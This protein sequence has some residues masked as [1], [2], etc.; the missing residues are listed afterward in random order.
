[1]QFALQLYSWGYGANSRLGYSSGKINTQP[2][3]FNI[4]NSEKCDMF[5]LKTQSSI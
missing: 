1:M 5:P 3:N 2:K 4:G